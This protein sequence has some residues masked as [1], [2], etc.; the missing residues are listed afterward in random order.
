[1]GSG[2]HRQAFTTSCVTACSENASTT[3][4]AGRSTLATASEGFMVRTMPW[5]DSPDYQ[6]PVRLRDVLGMIGL[7]LI[8]LVG[9][10]LTP[11]PGRAVGHSPAVG[12][13]R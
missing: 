7:I 13:R 1:M 12:V 5:S 4:A 8:F 6:R 3:A 10:E 11:S 2:L 9:Y